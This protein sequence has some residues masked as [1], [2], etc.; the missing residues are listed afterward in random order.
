MS[1]VTNVFVTGGLGSIGYKVVRELSKSDKYRMY[2]IDSKINKNNDEENANI[3]YLKCDL[4]CYNSTG[5]LFQDITINAADKNV[6]INFA[7]LIYNEP[8]ICLEDGKVKAHSELGWKQCIEGNLDT[9]FNTTVHFVKY[10]FENRKEGVVINASSITTRGNPGQLAYTTAKA[11]LSGF[12]NTIGKEMGP[13]GIR[14]IALELGY[15]D[16]E[17]TS[18]AV[19]DTKLKTIKLNNPMRRLGSIDDLV[20]CVSSIIENNYINAT[21]ISLDGGQIA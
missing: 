18:Q 15:F 8:I 1:K 14:C 10:L 20:Q 2:S 7:G 5:K 11:A 12:T 9:A 3:R 6:L 13:L 19:P 17:S 16:V 4:S 21:T